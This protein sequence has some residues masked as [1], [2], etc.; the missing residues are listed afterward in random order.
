MVPVDNG[1]DSAK[2]EAASERDQFF[3]ALQYNILC[4]SL[5]SNCIPWVMTAST[6]FREQVET[7][8]G[9]PWDSWKKQRVAPHYV[10]HFHKNL[11]TK[12]HVTFRYFWSAR[13]CKSQEDIPSSL[14][15]VS[16]LAEDEVTYKGCD[17]E[18]IAAKTMRGLLQE[19]LPHEGLGLA[20]FEHLMELEDEVFRWE[21]RGPRL[22][23]EIVTPRLLKA[24]ADDLNT[25]PLSCMPDIVTLN[26]YDVFNACADYRN[27]GMIESFPSA[28][29]AMGYAHILFKDPLVGRMPPSGLGIFWRAECFEASMLG[30]EALQ[31]ECG[32]GNHKFIHNIDLLENWHKLRK[33]ENTTA[34]S[35]QLE[36]I[37]DADR[38]N[39]A[40]LRL[41]HKGTDRVLWVLT[42]HLMTT[43]RDNAKMNE[44]PGEVRAGEIKTIR[45]AIDRIVS[46]GEAVLWTGDFNID[47][48][49][50]DVLAGHLQSE[51]SG[52]ALSIDTGLKHDADTKVLD[53]TANAQPLQLREAFDTK[54]RWGACVGS[55]SKGGTCTAINADRVEWID[56]M[57][58]SKSHLRV[59]ALTDALTPAN[60][61]PDRSHG[62]DHLPIAAA[63]E[64]IR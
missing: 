25:T 52:Q 63:L 58:Y 28:M 8:S 19:L 44:Y 16:F 18:T 53:W 62:S 6:S 46:P 49:N 29:Q 24:P 30:S 17:G 15:G 42:S 10:K 23:Q 59:L 22:F 9:T 37:P 61:I 39:C 33:E 45:E 13:C 20:L 21:S 60:P 38:K 3:V 56:Y 41:R 48:S 1:T 50:H 35:S 26:E 51:L 36:R 54:H 64:F 14:H 27:V 2:T 40:M 57:W 4:N 47:A 34:P 32:E 12:D 11:G 55:S 5:S 31:L 43:S 7:A